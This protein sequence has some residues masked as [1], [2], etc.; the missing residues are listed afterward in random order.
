MVFEGPMSAFSPQGA[1]KLQTG[2][3]HFIAGGFGVS[4]VE[5]RW[6]A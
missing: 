6:L 4:G 5:Q 2:L 1:N 3:N